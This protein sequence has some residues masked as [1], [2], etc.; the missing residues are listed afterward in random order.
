MDEFTR[1]CIES[2]I[3]LIL[4]EFDFKKRKELHLD[5]CPCYSSAPCHTVEG[6]NCFFCYCP[7][8]DSEKAEGGC[9]K[10]NPLGK[11]KWFGREGNEVSDKIWDCSDCDYPHQEK[12]IKEALTEL[13][14]GRK[15]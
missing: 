3:K 2:H 7:W 9:K 8:Y 13:F 12:V 1:R 14:Y 4:E 15:N 11:G 6:L 10:N 5:S